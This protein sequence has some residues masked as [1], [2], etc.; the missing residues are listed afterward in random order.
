[1][2]HSNLW[3][4]GQNHLKIKRN[5]LKFHIKSSFLFFFDVSCQGD[6]D[7]YISK[8][9]LAVGISEHGW[10][11][12]MSFL[13]WKVERGWRKHKLCIQIRVGRG[14]PSKNAKVCFLQRNTDFLWS[15]IFAKMGS[16]EALSSAGGTWATD[17]FMVLTAVCGPHAGNLGWSQ[18]WKVKKC[19]LSLRS[20]STTP[21]TSH[22]FIFLPI[23]TIGNTWRCS[24]SRSLSFRSKVKRGVIHHFVTTDTTAVVQVFAS[25]QTP[26]I[27]LG[28]GR[29]AH[30]EALYWGCW[31]QFCSESAAWD[32]APTS[33][34]GA[35]RQQLRWCGDE[36][37]MG[38]FLSCGAWHKA[39]ASEGT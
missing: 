39:F 10:A 14:V 31:W 29:V 35:V 33:R 25:S 1:M 26:T 3:S 7:V 27:S 12:V 15:S 6:D 13:D 36:P 32:W 9:L 21:P 4:D 30:W 38:G 22:H 8:A 28:D 2:H 5:Q 24:S 34:S 11:W 19:Q 20:F 37:V 16:V 18:W 23:L 17:R